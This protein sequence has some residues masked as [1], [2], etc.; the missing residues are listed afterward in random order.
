MTNIL[1]EY[2]NYQCQ[3]LRRSP[4]TIANYMPVVEEFLSH[5]AATGNPAVIGAIDRNQIRTFLCRASASGRAPTPAIWNLRLSAVRSLFEFLLDTDQLLAN[6]ARRLERQHVQ[7][8]ERIP[9]TFY[10]LALLA[11]TVER[12]SDL[13]Y[14]PRNCALLL[15]LV[16][17]ALRVAEVVSLA[18]AQFDL[19]HRVLTGVRVKGGKSLV[20][21]LNEVAV[22]AI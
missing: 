5:H 18:V 20:I 16:H 13:A 1:S 8:H 17:T 7:S 14:R 19:E 3:V 10:E 4:R 15:T 2:S 22:E 6:P 9:L 11:A 21:V 12:Q